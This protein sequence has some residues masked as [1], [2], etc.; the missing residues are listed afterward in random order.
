MRN[1]VRL[2]FV[3]ALIAIGSVVGWRVTKFT[4]EPAVDQTAAVDPPKKEGHTVAKP[5]PK[6][7][8]STS[9]APTQAMPSIPMPP[10]NLQPLPALPALPAS[11]P[12][13]PNIPSVAPA[14]YS[15]PVPSP[16]LPIPPSALPAATPHAPAPNFELPT[17]RTGGSSTSTFPEP[18]L[19]T[20]PQSS[21]QAVPSVPVAPPVVVPAV[22]SLKLTPLA[23]IPEGV[24]P[25]FVNAKRIAIDYE[26]TKKG[27]SGL[28][29]VELWLRDTNGWQRALAAKP[30]LPLETELLADG[31]YGAKVVPVSGQGVRAPEPAKDTCPDMWVVIDTV[32]P[33]VEIK[34]TTLPTVE[35]KPPE[36]PFLIELTATDAN[37]DPEKVSIRYHTPDTRSQGMSPLFTGADLEKKKIETKIGVF[38]PVQQA[39]PVNPAKF[40]VQF[41]WTPSADAPPKLTFDVEAQ[42][43]A[44]NVSGGVS[45]IATDLTEPAAK[46]TGIRAVPVK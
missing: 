9:V 23:A 3:L 22:P 38:V 43:R 44:G 35:G 21:G 10:P 46:V 31:V 39:G 42:D 14:A 18:A 19:P 11:F 24:T 1:S 15:P 16:S 37:L 26:V 45:T 34:V 33:R 4:P 32:P 17:L 41:R 30:G 13:A 20:I 2:V 29:T 40:T 36:A 8:V 5:E 27:A 25:S 12:S 7:P 28:G 6:P